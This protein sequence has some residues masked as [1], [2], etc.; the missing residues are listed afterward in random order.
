[1]KNTTTGAVDFDDLIASKEKLEELV[2]K[3]K[4]LHKEGLKYI[5][6]YCILPAYYIFVYVDSI[7]II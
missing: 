6:T 7:L 4:N 5:F 3:V 1:M 2:W